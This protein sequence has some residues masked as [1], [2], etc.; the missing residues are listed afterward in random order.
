[1][2]TII[3]TSL[4][5][6]GAGSAGAHVADTPVL[7]HTAEHGWLILALLPL[8]LLPLGRSRR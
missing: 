8:V 4:L 6:A 3:I 1:M 7:Q 5:I 2:K